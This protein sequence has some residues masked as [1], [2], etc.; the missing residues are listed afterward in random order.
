[1]TMAHHEE[2]TDLMALNAVLLEALKKA[3]EY[4]IDATISFKDEGP[5]ADDDLKL[6]NA[7]IAKAENR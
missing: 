5:E 4:V 3:R 6:I 7:A 1:M 2:V